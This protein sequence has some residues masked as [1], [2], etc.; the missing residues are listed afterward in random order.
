VNF[1]LRAF[2]PEGS[3]KFAEGSGINTVTVVETVGLLLPVESMT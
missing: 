2:D 3:I 1:P